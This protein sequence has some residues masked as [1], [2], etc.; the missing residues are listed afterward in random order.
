MTRWHVLPFVAI[1]LL[2]GAVASLRA[3]PLPC[4]REISG[5]TWLRWEH[6]R[7]TLDRWCESVGPPVFTSGRE[8]ATGISRLLILSWNVHVGGADVEELL[9]KALD[10]SGGETGLVVLM[11]EAFRAGVDVPELLPHD[12]VEGRS[13]SAKCYELDGFCNPNG[14]RCTAAGQSSKDVPKESQSAHL[15]SRW[16]GGLSQREVTKLVYEDGRLRQ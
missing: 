7:P 1:A 8:K 10:L 13:D 2:A 5:V 9:A 3:D 15:A 16:P 6:E 11:Q 4:L 14:I 12:R